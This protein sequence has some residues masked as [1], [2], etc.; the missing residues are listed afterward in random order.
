MQRTALLWTI[1]VLALAACGTSPETE[2]R[3]G[4]Q[5]AS[6]PDLG[7]SPPA[8]TPTEYTTS[9]VFLPLEA[10]ATRALVFD[11]ASFATSDSL[12]YRYLG[13]QLT[14]SRW[15]SLLDVESRVTPVR[16]PWRLFPVGELRLTVTAD[17]DPAAIILRTSS[18]PYTLELGN[19][20]DRWEDRAG[21]HHEIRE[22]TWTRRGQRIS[23]IAA[24]H[25]FAV[26]EPGRPARFGA[27]ERAVLR[28]ADGA[29]IVLFHSDDPETYG[30]SYAWMYADGLTRRWTALEV[31]VVE[32]ARS[33][34]L[35]RNVPIRTWFRIPEPDIKGE[36]TAAERQFNEFPV[37]RGPKP[38]NALYRVRGWIEF[39]GERR[40]VE[41]LLE[42]G[43][44]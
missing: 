4:T 14:G 35:R 37:D 43:E 15:R 7:G 12:S 32:V 28:S 31:R 24:Q 18:A 2:T 23:G 41:G 8:V 25:R 6:L 10:A 5:E 11:F 29:V 16:E 17:G 39:S 27:Y 19:L 30:D 21:T 9:L 26:P 3:S 33:A 20:L 38:Y 36:L 40:N 34:Q 22:A 1:Y 13:W 44:P 42:R